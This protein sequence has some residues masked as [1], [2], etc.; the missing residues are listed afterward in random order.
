MRLKRKLNLRINI[1]KKPPMK[2]ENTTHNV[3]YVL[4]HI[5][6]IYRDHHSKSLS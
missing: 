5:L 2:C 3:S 4:C 1:Y 6:I